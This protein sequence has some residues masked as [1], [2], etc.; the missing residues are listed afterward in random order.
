M[1]N[2]V[3]ILLCLIIVA[4]C[5][6]AKRQ[7]DDS[8]DKTTTV[9]SSSDPKDTSSESSSKSSSGS[10]SSYT[11]PAESKSKPESI[12][13]PAPEPARSTPREDPAPI[14]RRSEPT[15][16]PPKPDP[17]KPVEDTSRKSDSTRYRPSNPD[18]E[19]V[20][21]TPPAAVSDSTSVRSGSS[22]P[23]E[24]SVKTPSPKQ[25]KRQETVAESNV[26]SDPQPAYHPSS[27]TTH[28]AAAK[29]SAKPSTPAP[30][31]R[32]NPY[33]PSTASHTSASHTPVTLPVT[34]VKTDPTPRVDTHTESGS[35]TAYQPKPAGDAPSV[36]THTQ[37]AEPAAARDNGYRPGPTA[38]TDTTKRVAPKPNPYTAGK[39][40]KV[41]VQPKSDGAQAKTLQD[42]TK[43]PYRPTTTT[44]Y[45]PSGQTKNTGRPPTVFG[46][47]AGR[48][49]SSAGYRPTDSRAAAGNRPARP[50]YKV[51]Y[52]PSQAEQPR[53]YRPP[54]HTNG[55]WVY[56]TPPI[57]ENR[58]WYRPR[59]HF[60]RPCYYGHW[61]DDYYPG[62]S[63][64]S[65]F[66]YFDVYPYVEVTTIQECPQETIEF[67][68]E[69]IY[70]SGSSYVSSSRWDRID[71]ALADIRSAWISAR[72]DL[73][74]Q[75]VQPASTMA[76]LTDGNY[77]YAISTD[78]YLSMTEDAMADLNTVSFVW[79]KVRERQDGTVMA[80]ADHSY[81]ANDR[82]TTVYVSYTLKKVG[83]GYFITEVGSSANPLN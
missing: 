20:K 83:S 62:F 19:P 80:F 79:N 64:R 7:K 43:P 27:S 82:A 32:G 39:E 36:V 73:I 38:M 78:D 33:R 9:K 12:Y 53:G 52:R 51:G 14:V 5:S 70:V 72:F 75:H 35:K 29:D 31:P 21:Y 61:A 76:V 77:D 65:L 40:P 54:Q 2:L 10:Q 13:H 42:A 34:T 66:F 68:S 71:E 56:S 74:K 59:P 57:I 25:S 16:E 49:T 28:N 17:P 50:A 30:T 44:S 23:S 15:P 67:V 24:S 18:P 26:Q 3:L 37:T 48:T 22:S 11:P 46:K 6:G 63:W 4:P 58:R 47:P 8:S 69:P 55:R 60:T 41:Q 81:W 1:R 45:I